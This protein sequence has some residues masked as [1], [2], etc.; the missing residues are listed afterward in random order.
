MR[1]NCWHLVELKTEYAPFSEMTTLFYVPPS[2]RNLRHSPRSML[3][4]TTV[5]T[6]GDLI[7]RQPYFLTSSEFKML[8]DG[9]F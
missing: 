1:S 3:E 7:S 8:L 6:V 5:T 9:F 4:D 2:A